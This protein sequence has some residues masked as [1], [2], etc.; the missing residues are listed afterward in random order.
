[1]RCSGDFKTIR[2]APGTSE[3]GVERAVAATFRL[4]MGSFGIVSVGS[5]SGSGFDADLEGDWDVVLLPV[6]A[7]SVGA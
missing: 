5:G 7:T 1:M 2:I 3:G 6:V 4:A